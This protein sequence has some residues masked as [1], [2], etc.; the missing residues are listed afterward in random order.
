MDVDGS[1]LCAICTLGLNLPT[2]VVIIW[3]RGKAKVDRLFGKG[4]PGTRTT[5]EPTC[6]LPPEIVEM[7]IAHCSHSR[8][9][10]KA[11]SLT[12]RSW[13]I[14]AV[15][16]I[17]HILILRERKPN[18]HHGKLKPLSKLHELGLTPLVKT[19]TV[20]QRLNSQWFTPQVFSR[21]DL[22]HFSAF[23]NVRVLKIE[24]M[25][26]SSFIPGIERYFKHFSPTL[27]SIN[28]RN[29]R[30][31]PRQLSYFLS[32]FPNL[33]DIH[34]WQD[35]AHQ[36]DT[37]PATELVPFSAPGL[38]GKL[39]LYSCHWTDTWTHLI[40]SGGGLRFRYI[41]LYK[42]GGCAP[43]LF[44]ACA[45]TLEM[46]RFHLTNGSTGKWLNVD[47]SVDSH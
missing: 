2:R 17:H 12:C 36:P 21:R 23:T 29:P 7:I 8:V 16:H 26:I 35:S 41:D 32:L 1:D 28:L 3:H 39:T 6:R 38:R 34:I 4:P 25:D 37:T 42:A 31:T 43:M 19:I 14:A 13:Y 5:R 45:E 18:K 10:L 24:H 33:D 30:C 40:A 11:C 20:Y 22:R 46:L 9:T 44:E 47:L 15:P 27:H